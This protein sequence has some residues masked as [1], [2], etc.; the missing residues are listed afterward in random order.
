MYTISFPEINPDAVYN[1][2]YAQPQP[3]H[4]LSAQDSRLIHQAIKTHNKR[5]PSYPSQKNYRPFYLFT[6]LH[7]IGLKYSF[8][9]AWAILLAKSIF[10]FLVQWPKSPANLSTK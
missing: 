7:W 2:Y 5:H 3:Y 1:H 10:P 9:I 6:Y 4:S 8:I